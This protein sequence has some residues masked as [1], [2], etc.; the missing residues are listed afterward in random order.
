LSNNFL[1]TENYL[2]LYKNTLAF[3]KK[4][5]LLIIDNYYTQL[6]VFLKKA[7]ADSTPVKA[8]FILTFILNKGFKSLYAYSAYNYFFKLVPS[9]GLYVG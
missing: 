3:M 6:L 1:A 8:F 4:A 7:F 9:R 5:D 2:K